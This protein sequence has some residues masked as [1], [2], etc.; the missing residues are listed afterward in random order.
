MTD[1]SFSAIL[2]KPSDSI[3]R[4]KPLPAGTYL[5][6]VVGQPRLD[7]SKQKGTPF[8]EFTLKLVQAGED[9]DAS[10]LAEY[11]NGRKLI[12][13]TTRDTYYLTDEAAYRLKEFIDH[14]GVPNEDG[15]TLGQRLAHVPGCQLLISIRHKPS[16]D[17]TRVYANVAQTA[18]VTT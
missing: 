1:A 3:E 13:I 7:K 18:A 5:A 4:P 11:L 9:V 8:A 15:A 12:E 16:D 6:M 10:L 2:D 14:C 17:G